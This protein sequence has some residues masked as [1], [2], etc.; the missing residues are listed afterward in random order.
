MV[1]LI[2]VLVLLLIVL[3]GLIWQARN[4]L[5]FL[6][7][8]VKFNIAG[9]GPMQ[10]LFPNLAFVGLFILILTLTWY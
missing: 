5:R 2:G 9:D 4:I 7:A 8:V 10:R 6:T 1:T 3:A